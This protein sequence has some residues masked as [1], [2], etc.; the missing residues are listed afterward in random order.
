MSS[1]FFHW[2]PACVLFSTTALFAG[3]ALEIKPLF[4]SARPKPAVLAARVLLWIGTA[5]LLLSVWTGY[6]HPGKSVVFLDKS[7]Q[8]LNHRFLGF[9]IF[10]VFVVISFWRLLTG[11]RTNVLLVLVW[12]AALWVLGVQL[13]GGLRLADHIPF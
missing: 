8:L 7:P 3:F 5:G 9:W 13:L 12:L 4:E 11:R 1:I 2:H 6:L 10:A